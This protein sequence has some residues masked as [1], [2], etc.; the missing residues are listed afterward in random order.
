MKYV[1]LFARQQGCLPL[2]RLNTRAGSRGCGAKVRVRHQNHA[3]V[4]QLVEGRENLKRSGWC[5]R[6]NLVRALLIKMQRGNHL[7]ER[8]VSLAQQLTELNCPDRIAIH[9][10]VEEILGISHKGVAKNV[11]ELGLGQSALVAKM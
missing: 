10:G 7:R 9:I 2:E 4:A 6:E 8:D 1:T 11:P 5:S 3:N